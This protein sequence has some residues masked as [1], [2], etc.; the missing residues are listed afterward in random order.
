[1]QHKFDHND[2]EILS[3]EVAFDG[4]FKIERYHLRHALFLG[5]QSPVFQREL[6]ERGHAVAVLPYDPVR[7][8][9]V[10]IEQF[11]MGAL[12]D[13]NSPWLFEIVAGVI[14][15]DETPAAVATRELQ[16]E[17]GLHCQNLH[18]LCDYWVSP[19]GSSERVYLF[20]AEVDASQAQGIHGLDQEDEDIRVFTVPF[21]EALAAVAQ[22]Q[23]DNSASIIAIQWLA[24]NKALFSP[25]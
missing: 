22:G 14:D 15:Q 12:G 13:P 21:S 8:E 1:M 7:D 10:L 6:F 20:L 4:F 11:R 18:H 2:L 25:K 24:L 5:G 9:V 16:E 17:A 19:G 3:K 23:I